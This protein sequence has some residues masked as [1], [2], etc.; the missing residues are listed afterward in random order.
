MTFE[1]KL[2]FMKKLYPHNSNLDNFFLSKLVLIELEIPKLTL[3]WT[4]W[5]KKI[6][7]FASIFMFLYI[8]EYYYF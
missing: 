6:L 3:N 4:N 8:D 5:T 1:V 2:H 7:S